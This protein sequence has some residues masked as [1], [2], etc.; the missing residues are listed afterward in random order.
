M[1]ESTRI[2]RVVKTRA[3]RTVRRGDTVKTV[4]R[5]RVRREERTIRTG[6]RPGGVVLYRGPSQ[7][8]G[9]PIVCVAVFKSRNAKT[10]SRFVQTFIVRADVDPVQAHAR[11]R[12]SSVCGSC[13][14]RADGT[15][16]VNL[17]Q[18]PLAVWRAYKRGAYPAFDAARHASRFA[19]RLLRL[20][21]YG[22]PA[23][24][25]LAVWDAVVPLVDGRTGYT[26]QWRSCDPG[27][28][29][30]C[31]ASCET[32]ADREHALS[33]G[34]RT[35]RVRVAGQGLEPGEFECPASEEQ[36]KRLSCAECQACCGSDGG[37][38]ASP[39]IRFHGPRIAGDWRARRYESRVSETMRQQAADARRVALAVLS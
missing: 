6:K 21:A 28:A 8:D 27:Y 17:V 11:G 30:Y 1:M 36:G 26:H 19:G 10:G 7:L 32:P 34:Y 33:L 23:A 16:Y 15:C 12:D 25:P 22:D 4:E 24:V 35:F 39:S 38:R 29:R 20:G 14:H 2:L 3:R 31:M 13:V 18:A 5:V 37:R 9:K